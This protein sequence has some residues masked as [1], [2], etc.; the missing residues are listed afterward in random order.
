M[1]TQTRANTNTCKHN[2]SYAVKLASIPSEKRTQ[3]FVATM[4]TQ[5]CSKTACAGS[6]ARGQ[7]QLAHVEIL[8]WSNLPR[9]SC[10][11]REFVFGA[12]LRLCSCMFIV[13]FFGRG[14]VCACFMFIWS[15]CGT[16]NVFCVCMHMYVC[17]C[18]CM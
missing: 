12:L 7:I 17:L 3:T 18:V 8:D 10:S 9:V 4:T 1:R 6:E 13:F 14:I 2:I 16:V 11:S 5:G 15:F